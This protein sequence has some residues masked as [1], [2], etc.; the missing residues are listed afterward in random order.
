MH[1]NESVVTWHPLTVEK[2]ERWSDL[3]F[4][5]CSLLVTFCNRTTTDSKGYNHYFSFRELYS[6]VHKKYNF[7]K[8]GA[9]SPQTLLYI[10]VWCINV[11]PSSNADT[12]YDFT[13]IGSRCEQRSSGFR[14]R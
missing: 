4:L 6:H 5:L 7:S 8:T 13:E 11:C 14:Q 12:V 9:T 2:L 10:F 3:A 1:M